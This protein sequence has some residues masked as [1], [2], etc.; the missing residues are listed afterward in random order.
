[1]PL[2]LSSLA[3]IERFGLRRTTKAGERRLVEDSFENLVSSSHPSVITDPFTRIISSGYQPGVGGELVG[4]REDTQIACCHQELG[5]EDRT[6]TGQ[7][8]EDPGL[9]TGEKTTPELLVE[10]R[11]ALLESEHLFGELGDYHNGDVFCWQ[12]NALGSG[13]CQSLLGESI[14]PF[15]APGVFE[16]ITQALVPR[17]ADGDGGL[18][19][20]NQREGALGVQV[21]RTLQRGK[22]DQER[23][24]KTGYGP[25]LVGDEI[26]PAGEEELQLGKSALPR[27]EPAK[28]APHA[29]LIGNDM[30]VAGIGL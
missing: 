23:L 13:R 15:D 17:P 6:H 4:A 10:G 29:D 18:V 3:V 8:S 20:S 5:S 2:A 21:Q 9:G 24:P 16:V 14:G 11:E 12:S 25:G 30:S 19:V 27:L 26:T 22:Q 7:A 1:V 28:V